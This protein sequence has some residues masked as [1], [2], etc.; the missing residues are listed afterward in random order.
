MF[1]AHINK[2]VFELEF[3]D[4]TLQSGKIN[5]KNFQ[6]DLIKIPSILSY[7][8]T[9]QSSIALIGLLFQ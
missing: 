9:T 8:N 1:T 6:L 3:T 4:D 2:K 7:K 5:D